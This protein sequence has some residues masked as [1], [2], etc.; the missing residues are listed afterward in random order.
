LYDI[1]CHALPKK[2]EVNAKQGAQFTKSITFIIGSRESCVKLVIPTQ[3]SF[4]GFQ[5]SSTSLKFRRSRRSFLEK[6]VTSFSRL[7]LLLTLRG[8]KLSS[9]VSAWP[10]G[11]EKIDLWNCHDAAD[12][13]ESG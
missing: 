3:R 13:R 7:A 4:Q 8:V 10:R 5:R 2:V 11:R 12:G 9:F 1:P 6:A